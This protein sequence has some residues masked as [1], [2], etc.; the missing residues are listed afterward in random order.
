MELCTLSTREDQGIALNAATG[1][2]RWRYD[3]GVDREDLG[4]CRDAVKDLRAEGIY[5]PPSLRGTLLFPGNVGGVNWGIDGSRSEVEHTVRQHQSG[6][7]S[8]Q[9]PSKCSASE[10][11]ACGNESRARAIRAA[12]GSGC[13]QPSASTGAGSTKSLPWR[14]RSAG[15]F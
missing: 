15:L 11:L 4:F 1:K 8:Y 12:H 6:R 2:E 14:V 5:T 9:A 13:L 3:P 10:L 7:V